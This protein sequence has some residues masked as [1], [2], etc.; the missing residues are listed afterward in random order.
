MK[1]F[2]KYLLGLLRVLLMLHDDAHKKKSE[3][4]SGTK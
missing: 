3:N 1:N 2:L 4:S